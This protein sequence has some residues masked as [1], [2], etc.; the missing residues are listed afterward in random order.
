M[1]IAPVILAAAL[2]GVAGARLGGD[3]RG[4]DP[5]DRVETVEDL[6]LLESELVARASQVLPTVVN[7]RLG[8]RMGGATGTGVIISPDGLVA[9]CGHVGVRA[10]RRVQ[11]TL[12]DGTV[13]RG[14]TLGQANLGKLDCGLVQ[15]DT[16]GKDLPAAPLGRSADL[17]TGDWLI[18]M[19]Y[20]QGPPSEPRPALVRVGRVT[21]A[22]PEEV[23]FDGPIDAGDSGG[24][25]FNLR[26]EVVAINSRCGSQP[27]ENA[28]TPVDRLRERMS[29]FLE[30]FNEEELV[31]GF[32]DPEDEERRIG[33]SFG[34]R[35]SPDSRMSVQR[36]LPFADIVAPAMRSMVQV[37]EGPAVRAVGTVV[38]AEGHVATKAS[39]LPPG[40]R[41]GAVQLRDAAGA[42]YEARV[43]GTDGK[44]D[45]AVL[46]IEG[47]A[48][49]DPIA[50]RRLRLLAPG[51]V[52]LTPRIGKDG[53]SLGF[54]SINLRES[55]PDPMSRPYLGVRTDAATRDELERTGS[56]QAV[57]VDEVVPG[58]AAAEAGLAVG[59]LVVTVNGRAVGGRSGL[60]RVLGDF[61]V[62]DAVELAVVRGDQRMQ[63]R[64]TLRRRPAEPGL[65]AGR[66]NTSTPI[67][68]VSTG[69]GPVLAHDAIVWPDQC[70]GPVLDL[71]GNAVA[72]N[73]ARYDRTATHAIDPKT[74]MS[75]VRRIIAS[76]A[77]T[78]EA[79]SAPTPR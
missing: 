35:S 68:P 77:G 45:L 69:F 50:W 74:L 4:Q 44:L 1:I 10:G 43:V 20:T 33:T 36:D 51:Q 63:L 42:T 46:R 32:V 65:S 66:G 48:R 18:V 52:L 30:R 5:F 47:D 17:A 9:T 76:S 64:A 2:L 49:P 40:A 41:E 72:W 73:V 16:E 14:T 78:R 60:A 27:W 55:D 62:G 56:E 34:R 15:L 11:A 53:P 6:A 28:A 13:L 12:S 24:P 31:F 38:D 71:Q 58:S 8:G 61:A 79:G 7:L 25:S 75:A 3:V 23:L 22:S 57:R 54:V 67:S 29:E 70:G 19:G 59:D 37:M 21:K 39:Q 26:G